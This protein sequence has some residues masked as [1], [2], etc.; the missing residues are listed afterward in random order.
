MFVITRA[1]GRLV[2]LSQLTL[3]LCALRRAGGTGPPS[4]LCLHR[5]R[6]W[7]SALTERAAVIDRFISSWAKRFLA[8]LVVL[9]YWLWW[10]TICGNRELGMHIKS[11]PSGEKESERTDSL[12][13]IRRAKTAFIRA[14]NSPCSRFYCII[15]FSPALGSFVWTPYCK[16]TF[17]C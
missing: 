6:R 9:E 3:H 17:F 5:G 15:S 12:N 10:H 11:H 4:S 7:H 16:Y 13:R 8:H 2:K 14:A 1:L